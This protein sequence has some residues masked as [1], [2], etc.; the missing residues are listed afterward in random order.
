MGSGAP[1][2]GRVRRPEDSAADD[3]NAGTEAQPVKTIPA[4][5]KLAQ[6]GDTVWVKEGN[7]ED[8]VVLDKMATAAK[9][10]VLSA[11]K[12]HRVRIGYLPRALPV[13]GDWQPVPGSKSCRIKLTA[14]VPDDFLLL[15][16]GKA[17][18]TWPQDSPPKDEKVNWASYRK[19]DRTLM[20]N[21]NGKNP[22]ALGKFEYGRTAQLPTFLQ[23]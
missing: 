16:D 7:Y 15:L 8:R 6:P 10:L 2:I 21:A 5:I 11:W 14:D 20:F 3:G 1:R 4:G 23:H 9:P 13:Q 18:L 12:D 19:S 17:I 22:A